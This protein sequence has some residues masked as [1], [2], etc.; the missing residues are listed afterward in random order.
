ME[1]LTS[2]SF[3][4]SNHFEVSRMSHFEHMGSVKLTH[5]SSSIGSADIATF[6]K[7]QLKIGEFEDRMSEIKPSNMNAEIPSNVVDSL[8][9]ILL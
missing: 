5:R 1:Q 2:S 7:L 8:N 3:K 4:R 9:D 6:N